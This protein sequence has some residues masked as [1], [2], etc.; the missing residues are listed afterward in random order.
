MILFTII[1][2]SIGIG[3]MLSTFRK[4][5]QQNFTRLGRDVAELKRQITE[6][7][8]ENSTAQRAAQKLEY[9]KTKAPAAQYKKTVP[10]A[11]AETTAQQASTAKEVPN[12]IHSEIHKEQS[13]KEKIVT[14]TLPKEEKQPKKQRDYEK[15]IGE[16]WL[17][18][19]GIAI[20]VIGVGFFVKYAIDQNWIGEW[21]RVLIGL[22]S[23]GVLISIAHF[24]R[25]KYAAFSSVLIGGGISICITPFPLPITFTDY[26][27]N[28]QPLPHSF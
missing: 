18:K 13:K 21:G 3:I 6:V 10:Y 16:N 4:E 17:N 12:P 15:L 19:I 26:F 9:F 1:L 7:Q 22:L 27:R 5:T 20:L 8:E 14:S 23:G 24:L 25:K 11:A 2:V 28:Q